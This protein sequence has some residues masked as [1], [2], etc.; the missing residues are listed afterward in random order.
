MEFQIDRDI[1]PPHVAMHQSAPAP[2][3]SKTRGLIAWLRG[4]E[5]GESI[6][7]P[8]KTAREVSG[9]IRAAR[10]GTPKW[11][12]SKTTAAGARVWRVE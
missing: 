10:R 1:P 12:T 11:F 5:I 9:H 3:S 8:E 7:V 2:A 6:L 4:L